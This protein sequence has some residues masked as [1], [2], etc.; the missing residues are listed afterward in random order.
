VVTLNNDTTV[1]EGWLAALVSAAESA[2]DIGMCA[3]KMLF[4]HDPKTINSAGLCVDRLGIAWDRLGG[5]HDQTEVSAPTEVFGPSGGAALYR[6]EMLDQIGLFDEDF[7]AYLEDVDLAWRARYSGWRCLYVSQ[8]RVLHHHSAT[9]RRRSAFKSYHLGRNKVWTVL[10]NYPFRRL[11][12]YVPLMIFYDMLAIAYA[13][14]VRRDLHTL[15]GRIAGWAQTRTMLSK[16]RQL[17]GDVAN[18]LGGLTPV[19]MPWTSL[20]NQTYH[21][22]L[23]GTKAP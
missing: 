7:F 11:W 9:A 4:A 12:A 18:V 3:S 17:G 6:R 16:R 19:P 15:R 10:K 23:S 13:S 22:H 8:A 5:H 20:G 2:P 1:S 21:S 14:V